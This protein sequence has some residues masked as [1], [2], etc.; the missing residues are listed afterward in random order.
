MT[1]PAE[2][3]LVAK[4]VDIKKAYI[5]IRCPWCDDNHAHRTTLRGS[6]EVV[7]LCHQPHEPLRT[8]SIPATYDRRTTP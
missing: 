3:V 8:Y 2:A 4:L 5:V 1:A 7:A 6:N